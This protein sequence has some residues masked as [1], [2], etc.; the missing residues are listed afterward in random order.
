MKYIVSGVAVIVVVMMAAVAGRAISDREID[1]VVDLSETNIPKFQEVAIPFINQNDGEASLPFLASAIIDVDGDGREEL[2][3]GGGHGQQDGLFRFDGTAFVSLEGALGIEKRDNDT[4]HGAVVL[5]FNEDGTQDLIVARESGVWLHENKAGKFENRK[6]ELDLR[7][8][9]HPLSIAVA[10]LNGDGYFDMYVSGYIRNDMVQGLN[11][12]N[13]EGYGGSSE[14]YINR[15]DNTF[16]KKT[17]DWGLSYTHNTFHSVFIDVDMDGDLDLVVAHDTGQIRTW[18]NTGKQFERVDN[19]NSNVYSYPMGIAVADYDNNGLV[20]FFF[21][22]VGS[23]PPHFMVKGDLR[24]D[25]QHNWKWL[26]FQNQGDFKLVDNAERAKLADYEFAWGNVFEDLNLDGR[27]DLV[28][29]QNFVSMPLHKVPALRLPGRLLVQNT[30]GEFAEVGEQAGVSNPFYSIAP[31]TADFNGD[32]YPDLIHANLAGPSKAF[33]S[34]G[35]NSSYLKI[36]LPDTVAS[37]GAMVTVTRDDGKIFYLPYVS[38]EG[39]C[40]DSSRILV[41][42]L[43]G[44]KAIKVSVRFIDGRVIEREGDF[45]NELLK[46]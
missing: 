39:L 32:G 10:D 5:D 46:L 7:D 9:T 3:L 12:F 25:Q 23:T 2:F 34:E 6:L 15:G 45:H 40:S 28:V 31:L 41:A 26:L 11:I 44:R 20:D 1:Y 21:S 42:G 14:L 24:D 37:I 4:T 35:G 38:G 33:L 27:P 8:D 22:N 36:Q 18:E 16:E 43:D 19:P 29:S 30:K 13:K 17:A